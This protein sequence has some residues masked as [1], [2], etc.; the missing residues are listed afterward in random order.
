MTMM[1]NTA[2][3]ALSSAILGGRSTTT[4]K[5]RSILLLALSMALL[6]IVL[7]VAIS[8]GVRNA[9]SSRNQIQ[10]NLALSG[11]EGEDN[12]DA[13]GKAGKKK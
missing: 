5:K 10:S 9:R 1:S 4:T 6:A 13:E 8:A 3:A 11:M 12:C 7:G 2:A